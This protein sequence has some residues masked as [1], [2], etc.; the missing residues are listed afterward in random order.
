M[1]LLKYLTSNF[2]FCIFP[3]KHEH[4]HGFDFAEFYKACRLSDGDIAA[5]YGWPEIAIDVNEE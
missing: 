1:N 4:V 5:R 3:K 2:I